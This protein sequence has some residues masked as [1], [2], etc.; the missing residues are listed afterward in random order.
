MKKLILSC[1]FVITSLLGGLTLHAGRGD[2]YVLASHDNLS[3]SGGVDW[4]EIQRLRQRVEL[5]FL[6][7]RKDGREWLIRD[8]SIVQKAMS[9]FEPLEKFLESEEHAIE[10]KERELDDLEER[11]ED[12]EETLEDIE[13][14]IEDDVEEADGWTE[15]LRQREREV[16][17]SMR[18]L[19]ER[20][21]EI[22]RELHELERQ[23]RE[24]ERREEALEAEAEGR[25]WKLIDD[26]I[27]DGVAVGWR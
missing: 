9:L 14:D 26:A 7:V 25:L 27:R 5:P 19:E 2:S 3:V 6:W 24:V 17:K 15:E 13:D 11:L 8:Y 18:E 20:Q 16:S 22:E 12:E 10:L 4:D 23:E 1:V 21:R